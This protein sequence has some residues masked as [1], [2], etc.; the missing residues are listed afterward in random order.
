MILI[1]AHIAG[2]ENE[3]SLKVMF[4]I[5]H[6]KPQKFEIKQRTTQLAGLLH[7]K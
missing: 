1:F 2:W 3:K 4:F 6:A 5:L 7:V